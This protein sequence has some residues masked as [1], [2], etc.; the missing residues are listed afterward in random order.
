MSRWMETLTG[1]HWSP[2][3]HWTHSPVSQEA[4]VGCNWPLKAFSTCQK[5]N[6]AGARMATRGPGDDSKYPSRR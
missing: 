5:K 6:G 4:L 3:Q 1:E 2:Q